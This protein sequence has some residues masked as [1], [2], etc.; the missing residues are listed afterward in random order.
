[1]TQ[2]GPG[3]DAVGNPV[4]DPTANVYA[5]FDAGMKHQD[6]MRRADAA[7]FRELLDIFRANITNR[8]EGEAARV[9]SIRAVDVAQG[10]RSAEVAENRAA[11]LA[12]QVQSTA[13]AL[14][15]SLTTALEP[16]H[17]SLA[18]LQRA[19]YQQQGVKETTSESSQSAQAKG[20]NIGMWVGIAVAVLGTLAA[21]FMSVLAI[22]VTLYLAS[23]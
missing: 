1:M 21:A 22:G 5:L 6:E 14:A 17:T 20:A 15:K 13:D 11:V 16:I 12:A 2:P 8:L 10:Q 3:V 9:N 4:L 18:E 23:R 19:L 7:H